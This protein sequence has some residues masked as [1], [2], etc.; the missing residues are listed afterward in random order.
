MGL[1]KVLPGWWVV[2][3]CD[4]FS[5]HMY[6]GAGR[7]GAK[8]LCSCYWTVKLLF[9]IASAPDTP[10]TGAVRLLRKRDWYWV[11]LGRRWVDSPIRPAT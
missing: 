1:R 5:A 3:G 7:L 8:E 10:S 11:V 4:G 6:H 9:E 2:P